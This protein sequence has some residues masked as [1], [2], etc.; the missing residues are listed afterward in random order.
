MR[1]VV[2]V[3]IQIGF[4]GSARAVDPAESGRPVTAALSLFDQ[5]HCEAF[6]DVTEQ[7]F[8]GDPELNAASARLGTATHERLSRIP[9]RELA[10]AENAEWARNRNSS[11]G[12]FG[13]Q[14]LSNQNLDYTKACLLKETEERIA[15]LNDANFDCLATNTTSGLLICSDP[16]LAIA[17]TELNEHVVGLIGKL[18]GEDVRHA[19]AEYER[20]TRER[21]R[22]CNLVGKDNVPLD[23]LSS[24]EACLV[25]H[26]SKTAEI[27]AAKGD[28]KKVFGGPC[29]VA[30]ARRRCGRF[31]CWADSSDQYM[32]K[33]SLSQ[34][35]YRA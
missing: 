2:L 34:P 7:L 33:L 3:A 11:C 8:C 21:D 22:N 26:I 5:N 32:R 35:C 25:Q 31:V 20:W 14:K 28:P 19:F 29:A 4:A 9:N 17:K 18:K 1:G 27:V 16:S 24:S 15:I 23:E 13:R 30:H 10:I 12:I 6:K